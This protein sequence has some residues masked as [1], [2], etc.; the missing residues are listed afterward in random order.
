MVLLLLITLYI[1][2]IYYTWCNGTKSIQSALFNGNKPI[3]YNLYNTTP[4]Y[5]KPAD[6]YINL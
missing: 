5:N 4:N 6:K 3:L 1:I 2:Y